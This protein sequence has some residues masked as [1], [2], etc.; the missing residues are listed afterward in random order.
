MKAPEVYIGLVA[1]RP[2]YWFEFTEYA[3]VK[4]PEWVK[5]TRARFLITSPGEIWGIFVSYSDVKMGN[6][7]PSDAVLLPFSS[8]VKVSEGNILK[9]RPIEGSAKFKTWEERLDALLHS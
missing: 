4:R 3:A 7:S 1:G 9:V 5:G 8:V 6:Q 2:P